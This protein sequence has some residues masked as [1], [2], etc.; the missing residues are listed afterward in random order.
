[1]EAILQITSIKVQPQWSKFLHHR[2]PITALMEEVAISIQQSYPGI[3]KLAQTPHWLMTE[4]K[5]QTSGKG[6]SIVVLSIAGQYI[7]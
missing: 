7:L 2:V 6:M 4:T 1:M 3:L 5:H